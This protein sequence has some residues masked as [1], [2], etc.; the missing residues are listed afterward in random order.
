MLMFTFSKP[1]SVMPTNKLFFLA[2]LGVLFF[3]HCSPNQNDQEKQT[4]ETTTMEATISKSAFGQTAD[5]EAVDL[6]TLTNTNGI[7]VKITNYG[8]IVTSILT[9][10]KNGKMEDIVLGFDSL[11]PYLVT[12]PYFGALVGR[13]GNRIAKGKFSIDGQEYDL[14]INN[15]VNHLH[16]G[17][18]GFDKVVW[19]A[20]AIE[21]EEVGLKLNYLSK[22]ME[23]GY[24]GNL[25]VE[26]IYTLSNDNELKI[27]YTAT[28]DKKTMVNLTN[29][30]YF[31]LTG[32]TKRDILGHELML[33]AD[34]FVP[35]NE[36]LIPTG[37]LAPVAGTPFDFTKPTAIGLRVN[38][39]HQ[40]IQYGGGY[41]HCWVLNKGGD[42]LNMVGSVYEPT[43]GRFMEV[44]TTEPGVQFYCG[45]FLDGTLTGKGGVKYE[46][47][48]G[49]CLETEHY[50]DSPNQPDFPTTL[51]NP[52]E[53]YQ[54]TT[55]H[56]FFVKP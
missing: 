31:N 7:V 3:T 1:Q 55:V 50:P 39:E 46:H 19:T 42:D 20:E 10:D 6:Y 35:V 23:E 5:G 27:D 48:Y 2:I 56:K 11:P 25:D 18:K 28:T 12:H 32:G 40:Q 51:L 44:F 17:L 4:E 33:N 13:Y 15:G 43:S 8:G 52:G 38:D 22:D 16:G 21:G 49:L 45:N 34:Q 24:P 37:E 26:V 53:T 54:T 29:H 9:P 30:S 47:R 36:T 14:A 41:D